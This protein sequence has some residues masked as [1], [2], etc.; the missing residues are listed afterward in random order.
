MAIG[1]NVDDTSDAFYLDYQISFGTDYDVPSV[2]SIVP[3]GATPTN[4]ASVNYTVTFSTDVSGVDTTDFL[5]TVVSGNLNGASV[6]SVTPVDASHYTVA[7]STGSGD[8]VLRLDL[9]DD[10]SITSAAQGPLGGAGAG[11]GNFSGGT[12]YTIDRTPPT[13]WRSPLRRA[14][15]IRRQRDDDQL[16]RD[17]QRSGDGFHGVRR[18]VRRRCQRRRHDGDRQRRSYDLHDCGQW[19]VGRH[20]DGDDCCRG[21]CRIWPEMPALPR[22]HRP[23]S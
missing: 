6:T 9:V 16:H 14:G 7:V 15:L 21:R 17:V 18:G 1:P 12:P 22:P 10:D 23:A 5:A 4:A 13:K 2:V 3:V 20:F 11:N 19:G 8:G